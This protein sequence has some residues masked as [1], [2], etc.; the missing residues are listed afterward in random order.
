[1]KPAV[2]NYTHEVLSVLPLVTDDEMAI[3]LEAELVVLYFTG[4]SL[5]KQGSHLAA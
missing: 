5:L 1:M 4:Q 3:L 2:P